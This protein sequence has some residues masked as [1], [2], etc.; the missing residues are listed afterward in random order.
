MSRANQ[1]I[2]ARTGH[3]LERTV[4]TLGKLASKVL[5]GNNVDTRATKD[6]RPGHSTTTHLENVSSVQESKISKPVKRVLS[7]VDGTPDTED[8]EKDAEPVAKIRKV[9]EEFDHDRVLERN[10]N[11]FKRRIN[12]ITN[13]KYF[14]SDII[15]E[16]SKLFKGFTTKLMDEEGIHVAPAFI[17]TGYLPLIE[18]ALEF[19]KKREIRPKKIEY[20]KTFDRVT[21]NNYA[22]F[23]LPSELGGWLNSDA[24][25]PG[26]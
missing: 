13:S 15:Q 26:S 4:S 9:S 7:E 22:I 11:G 10:R 16:I 2:N 8:F 24:E 17:E 1:Q 20:Y 19:Q 21:L 3:E 12:K 5:S 25:A 18:A 23:D 6:L 14:N